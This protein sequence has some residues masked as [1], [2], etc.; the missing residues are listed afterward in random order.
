[1][2]VIFHFRFIFKIYKKNIYIYNPILN[3]IYNIKITKYSIF[4]Y[5]E[6]HEN[7]ENLGDFTQIMNKI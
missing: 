4:S 1:M 6:N 7:H 5:S 3:I 2:K